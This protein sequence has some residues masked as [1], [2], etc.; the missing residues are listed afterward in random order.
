[1]IEPIF[2]RLE[3][4]RQE[5]F[6]Q[7]FF[8]KNEMKSYYNLLNVIAQGNHIVRDMGQSVTH[9]LLSLSILLEID[10]NQNDYP[11]VKDLLF[12]AKKLGLSL[13]FET[14]ENDVKE[15]SANQR[16]SEVKFILNIEFL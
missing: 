7:E 10:S 5:K 16:E 13:D 11:V 9:G 14:F 6:L 2:Y 8:D 12:A 4:N 3:R 15:L 1:M